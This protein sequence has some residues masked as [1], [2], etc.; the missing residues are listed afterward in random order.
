V[1]ENTLYEIWN[2]PAYLRQAKLIYS[3]KALDDHMCGRCDLAI[4]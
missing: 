4:R 2:S 1:N 3:G